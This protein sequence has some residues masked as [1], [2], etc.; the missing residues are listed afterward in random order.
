MY[1][2]EHQQYNPSSTFINPALLSLPAGTQSNTTQQTFYPRSPTALEVRDR[3]VPRQISFRRVPMY[4]P[5][6][7]PP[8]ENIRFNL[9]G[10]VGPSVQDIIDGNARLDNA[11]TTPFEHT[12]HRSTIWRLYWAGKLFSGNTLALI[13]DGAPVT[14]GRIA[15]EI[16]CELTHVYKKLRKPKKNS[17]QDDPNFPLSR[18]ELTQIRLVAFSRYRTHWVPV[19]AVESH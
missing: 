9:R 3:N 12:G 7:F 6:Q 14:L 17:P 4:E 11:Q 8:S 1:T 2:Y 13:Q 16:A 10:C 15:Y 19:W 18:L 5:D